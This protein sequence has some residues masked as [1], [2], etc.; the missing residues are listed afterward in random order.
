M[1]SFTVRMW[2][3]DNFKNDKE[4]VDGS[5]SLVYVENDKDITDRKDK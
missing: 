3:L 5:W 2:N 1:A 4:K